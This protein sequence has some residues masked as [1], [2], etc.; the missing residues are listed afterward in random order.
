MPDDA[1]SDALGVAEDAALPPMGVVERV[2]TGLPIDSVERLCRRIAPGDANF[3]YRIVSKASL[4]RRKE[5]AMPRLSAGESEKLARLATVWTFAETVW[6]GDVA[7]RRFMFEQHP[8]LDNEAPIDVIL[9]SELGGKVVQDILGR[10]AF[11]SAV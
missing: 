3:K 8:L 1:L 11:G 10:L 9:S 7:A 5:A 6:G 2:R 4:A